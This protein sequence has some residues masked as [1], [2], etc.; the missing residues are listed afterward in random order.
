MGYFLFCLEI[1]DKDLMQDWGVI[2]MSQMGRK[3]L[4]IG[5]YDH[6]RDVNINTYKLVLFSPV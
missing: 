1:V 6:K 2:Y 3:I 4:E 5:P